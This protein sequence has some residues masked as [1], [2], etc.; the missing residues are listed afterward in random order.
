MTAQYI[1]IGIVIAAAVAYAG[2]YFYREWRENI[3]YRNYGCAGCAFYETCKRK[4]KEKHNPPTTSPKQKSTQA[5]P[6]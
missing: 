3:R 2:I 1:I 5:L 4:K 6:K